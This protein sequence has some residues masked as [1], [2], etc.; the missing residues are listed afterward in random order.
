MSEKFEIT[1]WKFV[2]YGQ[3][4]PILWHKTDV[5]EL[6]YIPADVWIAVISEDRIPERN[7][8]YPYFRDRVLQFSNDCE[9]I[10]CVLCKWLEMVI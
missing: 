6:C 2:D 1:A 5:E 4:P 7:C 3:F 8:T 9:K 10:S